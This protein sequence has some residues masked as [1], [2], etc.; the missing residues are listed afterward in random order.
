[1]SL[2]LKYSYKPGVFERVL[3]APY[4]NMAAAA[5]SA[6]AKAGDSV[7]AEARTDIASAGLG[8][9]F[10]QALRVDIYPKG[11]NSLNASAHVF[12]KIPYAGVFEEGATIRGKPRL[13]LPLS[14][15]PKRIGKKRMTPQLFTE[16]VAPLQYV[17]PPGGKPLLVAKMRSSRST[18]VTLA[19]IRAANTGAGNGK[20][21]SVPI[22]V[23]IDTVA[24]KKRLKIQSIINRAVSRLPELYASYFKAE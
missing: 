21:I 17:K 18:K 1:M 7:K 16:R 9:G 11:R 8:K 10:V 15:V 14:D 6:I 12:H 5:Q 20:I 13:W 19:R 2:R 23:G 4:V 3:N 22:F 24:V